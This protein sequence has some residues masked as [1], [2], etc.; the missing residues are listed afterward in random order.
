MGKA[1]SSSLNTRW[2]GYLLALLLILVSRRNICRFARRFR[3][4]Q[5]LALFYD[6]KG[7][8]TG[9]G[10]LLILLVIGYRG[11]DCCSWFQVLC[12]QCR[13]PEFDE[14]RIARYRRWVEN[15]V[16]KD[17]EFASRDCMVRFLE[18]GSLE[19]SAEVD[20]PF[21]FSVWR[22]S[23]QS[24]TVQDN[25]YPAADPEFDRKYDWQ[26]DQPERLAPLM[27]NA[28]F[29]NALRLLADLTALNGVAETTRFQMAN[30]RM[31]MVVGSRTIQR[32]SRSGQ[33]IL[34]ALQSLISV[35]QT[36]QESEPGLPPN[37][38]VR[39]ARPTRNFDRLVLFGCGILILAG[40]VASS[41]TV[42]MG[43]MGA[44]VGMG[45]GLC[46]FP[47]FLIAF[48]A[49]TRPAIAGTD[50]A[51]LSIETESRTVEIVARDHR[52]RELQKRY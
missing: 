33:S 11:A 47:L 1:E 15:V 21:S 52:L 49:F 44:N 45:M 3:F 38:P 5:P 32:D 16:V 31:R 29:T 7:V 28:N 4:A 48:L 43:L 41:W 39:E 2:T 13:G 26:T 20:A 50:E 17:P 25:P 14:K 6:P 18:S 24:S 46:F 22:V 23:S 51:D 10:T 8:L 27:Q 9:P 37:T 36:F 42:F 12:R 19:I 35:A 34:A 40:L 30:G